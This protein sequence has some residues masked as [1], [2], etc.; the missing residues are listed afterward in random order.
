VGSV[1]RRLALPSARFQRLFKE[2]LWIVLGQGMAM[3]GSLVGVRLL[4]GLL[5]PAQYGELA[6]GMTIATLLNQTLLG[7]LGQGVLRFYA[8]AVERGELGQYL[9]AVRRLMLIAIAMIA[10]LMLLGVVGL[11]AVG[12]GYWVAIVL[13]SMAFAS[14]NGCNSIL[15]GIQNAARQR[16]VVALSQ[17]LESWLRFLGAAGLIA[18]LGGTSSVSMIG[19]GGGG[20][21]VLALQWLYF[22]R[23]IP[24]SESFQLPD[25][26]DWQRQIWRYSW[27]I[28]TFGVFTWGQ[29]VSDRWALGLFGTTQEVGMYAVLY[30]LGYYPVSLATGMAVQFLAPVLFQRAGDASDTKRNTD[31]SQLTWRLTGLA[32]GLT[33]IMFG[34]ALL[35]HKQILQVFTSAHYAKLSYLFPWMV[36]AGGITA[37][38]QTISLRFFSQTKTNLMMRVKIFTSLFGIILNIVGASWYGVVGVVA[39]NV[40]FSITYFCWMLLLSK[41]GIRRKMFTSR[42]LMSV[43]KLLVNQFPGMATLY[44]NIRDQL[45]FSDAPLTTPWGFKLAG[46]A[47][48]AQGNFEPYE[49]KLI[50]ELLQ[51]ADIFIN[52][53]ANIG[54]YCCHALSLGKPVIAFEPIHRNL[55]YLCKNIKV[56]NWSN[57]EIF[58]IALSNQV[59]ILEIYGSNTGASVIKGWANI[60]E[61]YVTLVPASTVDIVLGDRLEGQRVLVLVDVE[62]AEKWMLEGA[63][64]FLNMTP[65]P[66]WVVEINSNEH[67]PKGVNVNPQLE[68]TFKI[69]FENGYRAF[70]CDVTMDE[71]TIEDVALVASGDKKMEVYNFIFR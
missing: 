54:Y 55:R 45:D 41:V 52:V 44:R 71:V 56:N 53:G 42:S 40:I 25:A 19:F 49:T 9:L 66:V 7:P 18:W 23:V 31:V 2:G 47:I 15:N 12:Q 69:F 6:L 57:A 58:P 35:W 38:A 60:P 48:M 63:N 26:T 51:D 34:G 17:G 70:T 46:H 30:Q 24:R 62:G 32:M 8:P 28:A 10:L 36:L 16:A 68:N 5:S 39:S 37:V 3:L 29:L 4:T 27:P 11:V 67:Q 64:G 14:V 13:A 59:G 33:A 43:A 65:R 20:S 1:G 22:R 21:L 50:R 61:N